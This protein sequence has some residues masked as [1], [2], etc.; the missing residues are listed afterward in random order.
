MLNFES[1][2]IKDS[3]IYK[4][5][6]AK[7]NN[8]SCENAFANLIV[9]QPLYNNMLAVEDGTL[10]I[11]SGTNENER[12]RIP[13]GNDIKTAVG[14]IFDYC[15]DRKPKFFVQEGERLER[16]KSAFPNDFVFIENRDSFDYLYDREKLATLE[17]KKYHSKR[18]HIASFSKKYDWKYQKIT[19]EN[20]DAVKLCAKEWYKENAERFDKYMACEKDGIEL[21]LN[22]MDELSILGGAVTVGEKV[23]AFTLASKINDEAVDIHIEKALK[24]YGEAYTVINREFAKNEL[25]SFKYINREDDLGLAGLRKAKLSYKPERLIKKY[26]CVT[27]EEYE[28]DKADCFKIYNEAFEAD[29]PFDKALFNYCFKYCRYLKEDNRVVSMLFELPCEIIGKDFVKDAFY[30]YAVA[31]DKEYRNRGYMTKL[32]KNVFQNNS[33]FL[34]LRPKS[35]ATEEYYKRQGFHSIYG[36]TDGEEEFT[37]KLKDGYK[38]LFENTV[39]DIIERKFT[40]MTLSDDVKGLRFD[41]SME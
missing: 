25:S 12:F 5:L 26:L 17:G 20:I 24:D 36:V 23:V 29:E 2:E 35:K 6:A 33:G 31:T 3:E 27:R 7:D 19:K 4:K 18:N 34:F 30:I 13:I 11:K 16:F 41:Y 10:F 21:L 38:E 32:L 1:I 8:I 37:V 28:K 15:G 39:N 14:K 9:W 22:N 40:L